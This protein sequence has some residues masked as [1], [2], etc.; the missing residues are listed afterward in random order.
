MSSEFSSSD[1]LMENPGPLSF[2]QWEKEY[3][4]LKRLAKENDN[5][6]I[7]KYLTFTKTTT[8]KNEIQHLA[9]LEENHTFERQFEREELYK[10]IAV[11]KKDLKI[12][13]DGLKKCAK[14]P[15]YINKIK[16]LTENIENKI[17][18][19]K[20]K[21]I[22]NFDKLIEEEAE[23]YDDIQGIASKIE[24]YEEPAQAREGYRPPSNNSFRIKTQKN[25]V[26][27]LKEIPK[28]SLDD[29]LEINSDEE[30][31]RKAKYN[32]EKKLASIKEDILQV[33]R[34]L[35]TFGKG[36]MGWSDQDHKTFLKLRTKHNNNLDNPN[37]MSDC[38]QALPFYK[39]EDIEE[40]IERYKDYLD[41]EKKKKELV[42][43][44]K[45]MK[46]IHSQMEAE[47][48]KKLEEAKQLQE[49]KKKELIQEEK[50]K[51]KEDISKW[52]IS[53]LTTKIGEKEND[54]A[55]A[56]MRKK[57][58]EDKFNA[59][60]E[61]I[62]RRVQ[63]YKE[64]KEMEKLEQKHQQELEKT[65]KR[66][67]FSKDDLLKIK[68]R[69]DLLFKKNQEKI[70]KKKLEV[71]EKMNKNQKV[72][73]STGSQYQH[74]E[75]RLT[76]ATVAMQTKQREKFDPRNGPGKLADNFAGALIRNTGRALVGWKHGNN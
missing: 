59:R 61:E 23:L 57:E 70:M 31:H 76:E 46:S 5:K 27:P 41:F 15:E 8:L 7:F 25:P 53:R 22:V 3:R 18:G 74:V 35:A 13:R 72:L 50:E 2:E 63:E 68:E 55:E 30:R 20:E 67:V 36:G 42:E 28:A 32:L 75:S 64:A 29:P 69:E 38:L 37:F 60:K 62:R 16:N 10:F 9:K 43:K 24:E 71:L 19:F 39:E 4:E 45:H 58:R 48:A 21:K 6:D 17:S 47:A 56:M 33:D 40:H 49:K 11:L 52:K 51:I 14:Q 65:M 66:K 34:Q 54:L 12:L 26:L 44:Y 73:E 1:E